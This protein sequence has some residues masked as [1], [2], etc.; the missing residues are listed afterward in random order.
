MT[1]GHEVPCHVMNMRRRISAYRKFFRLSGTDR[2]VVLKT[3]IGLPAMAVGLRLTSYA[4]LQALLG[5]PG[6][7]GRDERAAEVAL[8]VHRVAKNHPYR[9][10]C[11]KRS[12]TLLWILGTEGIDCEIEFGVRPAR[13]GTAPAFHAWV[14][15]NG[16][17]LNDRPDVAS[18]YLPF[19]RPFTGGLVV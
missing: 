12:L 3:T 10:N 17:V 1:A 16:E 14:T 11:L 19:D 5:R 15:K 4:R 7:S 2:L 8:L 13:N 9:A 6:T 18:E